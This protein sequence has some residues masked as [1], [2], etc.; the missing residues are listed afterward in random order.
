M[1]GCVTSPEMLNTKSFVMSS[2]RDECT[3]FKLIYHQFQSGNAV[4]NLSVSPS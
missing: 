2:S 1:R 3:S 4:S